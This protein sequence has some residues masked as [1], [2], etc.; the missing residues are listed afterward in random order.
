MF[1]MRHVTEPISAM[2]SFIANSFISIP[3]LANLL[4]GT[5]CKHTYSAILRDTNFVKT[6][7]TIRARV[8]QNEC[9]VMMLVVVFILIEVRGSHDLFHLLRILAVAEDRGEIVAT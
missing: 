5:T 6:N 8:G 3:K 9:G 7:V 1:V 2:D 4:H